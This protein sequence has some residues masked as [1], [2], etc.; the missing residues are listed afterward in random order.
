[1]NWIYLLLFYP[2]IQRVQKYFFTGLIWNEMHSFPKGKMSFVAVFKNWLSPFLNSLDR[3]WLLQQLIAT[4]S[5]SHFSENVCLMSTCDKTCEKCKRL[6]K[7][8]D[9]CSKCSLRHPNNQPAWNHRFWVLN[10][11]SCHQLK[12]PYFWCSHFTFKY[13]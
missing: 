3:K 7:E 12:V 11:F 4:P 13:C 9:L 1:M 10:N 8:L 5:I 6:G 2:E